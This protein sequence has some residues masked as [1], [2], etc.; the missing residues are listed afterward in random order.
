MIDESLILLEDHAHALYLSI[1]SGSAA[2]C[3]VQGEHIVYHT[4]FSAYMTRKKQ[5]FSQIKYLN[6]KG[7][8]RAGSRVRL[9]STI[10]FFESINES[11]TDLLEIYEID[12]IALDCTTTLI[13][14]LYQ[15][16]VPC[17]FAKKDPRLYK[18]PLHISQSNYTHL[19]GAIRQ[20]KDP[21][22]LYEENQAHWAELL[23]GSS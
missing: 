21:V 1:E 8:S 11:L 4:T 10:D 17:P 3:I 20:L 15:S 14:Y 12:R 6:K 23:L 7:K 22:L 9:A 19:E 5:G 2:L 18:I 13:P 16:K